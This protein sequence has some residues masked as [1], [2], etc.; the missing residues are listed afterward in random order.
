MHRPVAPCLLHGALGPGR[1]AL[2]GA[3]PGLLRVVPL[4]A[5]VVL[6]AP[7]LEILAGVRSHGLATLSQHDGYL[8]VRP[9]KTFRLAEVWGNPT[10]SFLN[11]YIVG[12]C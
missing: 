1:D 2:D 6:E 10:T 7:R 9:G 11:V 4:G 12:N 8:W 3:G 5:K